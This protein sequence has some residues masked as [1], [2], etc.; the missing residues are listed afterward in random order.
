V[1]AFAAA[2]ALRALGIRGGGI[3]PMMEGPAL[4]FLVVTRDLRHFKMTIYNGSCKICSQLLLKHLKYQYIIV[5]AVKKRKSN[6]TTN[7]KEIIKIVAESKRNKSTCVAT[8]KDVNQIVVDRQ[9]SNC[10]FF[11]IA[12]SS[13]E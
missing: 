8:S 11:N 5:V 12:C 4:G 10:N 13:S 1:A 9:R 3:G 2:A 6:C 7:E